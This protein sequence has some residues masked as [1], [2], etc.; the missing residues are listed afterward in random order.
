MG[1]W[2]V[3]TGTKF[4]M[5]P[6]ILVWATDI[7]QYYLLKRRRLGRSRFETNE[8]SILDLFYL[9]CLL[10]IQVEMPRWQVGKWIWSQEGSLG[11]RCRWVTSACWYY[12]YYG[13]RWDR[14]GIEEKAVRKTVP[15][16]IPMF[17]KEWKG[18]QQVSQ[19]LEKRV[20]QTRISQLAQITKKQTENW[21]Q[22]LTRC[23]SGWL[24]KN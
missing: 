18:N 21:P 23:R 14:P 13:T 10:A 24:Y 12:L 17:L 20:V 11:W 3:S 22:D 8:D 6:K 16:G 2:K 19:S 15:W 1:L 5:M 4:K 9:K 7:W